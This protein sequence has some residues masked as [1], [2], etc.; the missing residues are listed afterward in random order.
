MGKIFSYYKGLDLLD[1]T[2][3][4]QSIQ[5]TQGDVYPY[6]LNWDITL[7]YR[8]SDK[9]NIPIQNNTTSFGRVDVIYA[10]PNICLTKQGYTPLDV[11]VLQG[12]PS[13]NP[14]PNWNLTLDCL[15][16]GWV[17]VPA[18]YVLSSKKLCV[19]SI[20][21]DLDGT[22]KYDHPEV[23]LENCIKSI[24]YWE[25]GKMY[26]SNQ[27]VK[28]GSS[29]Y[30]CI[31]THGS[32]DLALDIQNGLL[33]E[34]VLD[35]TDI[36]ALIDKSLAIAIPTYIKN[37]GTPDFAIQYAANNQFRGDVKLQWVEAQS[38]LQIDGSIG[39][40]ALSA[41][42]STP[43]SGMKIYSITETIGNSTFVKGVLVDENG[44][45]SILFT[46]KK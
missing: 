15:F 32:T 25:T 9:I 5:V 45:E 6:D 22:I 43:T 36:Q 10:K 37:P 30:L 8:L 17:F 31:F 38:R 23:N 40:A 27:L 20:N 26:F 39:L 18:Q 4:Q 42:P 41:K 34:I 28:F 12:T 2:P 33:K 19:R 1:T 44:K 46:S 14:S 21:N 11:M 24:E 13:A 29:I 35:M 16:L 7:N 3:G